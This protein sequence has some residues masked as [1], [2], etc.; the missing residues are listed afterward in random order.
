MDDGSS[1]LVHR[2]LIKVFE[3]G[4]GEARTLMIRR[5]GF[6][7]GVPSLEV[8]S[9]NVRGA[10]HSV[11]DLLFSR[12]QAFYLRSRGFKKSEAINFLE[13]ILTRELAP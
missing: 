10:F 3:D 12:E 5:G 2:P 9:G 8:H 1:F 13:R 7:T 4:Y 11:K 6:L